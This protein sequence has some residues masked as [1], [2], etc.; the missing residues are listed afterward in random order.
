VDRRTNESINQSIID[1]VPR[2]YRFCMNS[3]SHLSQWSIQHK[4]LT[5]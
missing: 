2:L 3:I 5:F 1:A 4:V